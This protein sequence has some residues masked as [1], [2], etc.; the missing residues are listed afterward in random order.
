MDLYQ[1]TWKYFS[2][3]ENKDLDT[4]GDLYNENVSLIDWDI[5]CQGAPKVLEA[6]RSLF[7]TTENIKVD[8][9]RCSVDPMLLTAAAEIVITIDGQEIIVAD[10]ITYN[11]NGE[12][13][14]IRA[15]K[16]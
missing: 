5:E 2:A 8:I 6:N 7:D 10:I 3:F 14:N 1:L 9:T 16:G 12:I 4:L 13:K 15:Y 11:Q